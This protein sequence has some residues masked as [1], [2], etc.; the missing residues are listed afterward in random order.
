[1]AESH[2]YTVATKVYLWESLKLSHHISS[3]VLDLVN[4]K[5]GAFGM[6]AD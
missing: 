3:I 6:A 4:D 2:I 5:V 1:M